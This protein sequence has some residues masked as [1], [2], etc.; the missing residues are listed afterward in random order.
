MKYPCYMKHLGHHPLVLKE[1]WEDDLSGIN[2]DQR[3]DILQALPG[4]S[5]R[6]TQGLSQ[7][8]LLCRVHRIPLCLHTTGL[9]DFLL[10]HRCKVN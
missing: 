7:L 8:Y 3:Q 10:C 4:M 5:L 2:K 6:E 1:K 9:K